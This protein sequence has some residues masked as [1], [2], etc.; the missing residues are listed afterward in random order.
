MRFEHAKTP[1]KIEKIHSL[2]MSAFPEVERKP[3]DAI[4]KKSQE[5]MI[6]LLSIEDDDGSF[7]G[8]AI[9]ILYDKYVL[10]DYFAIDDTLRGKGYGKQALM[11]LKEKYSDKLF[12]LEIESTY[13][14][15]DNMED[16]KRRKGFYLNCGMVC[17]PYIVNF[18]G[19][20]ME[21]LTFGEEITYEE[22]K[23]IYEK[24][25]E[26]DIAKRISFDRYL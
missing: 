2:Y 18:L 10:L 3:F 26:G 14:E 13:D 16:R 17:M 19:T 9:N 23:M 21:V 1:E 4:V 5:G 12:L 25:F 15:C 6:D 24:S 11:Q 22:H 7:I 8:I 20:L